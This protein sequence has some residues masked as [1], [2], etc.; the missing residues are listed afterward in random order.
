[1]VIREVKSAFSTHYIENDWSDSDWDYYQMTL[2][3]KHSVCDH[4]VL[5]GR[6]FTR[7]ERN[8]IAELEEKMDAIRDK[9]KEDN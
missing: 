7:D 3:Q 6:K 2:A 5:D 8:F 9:Y 4:V 1:M